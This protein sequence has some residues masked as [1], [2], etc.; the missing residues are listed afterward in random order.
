MF[1]IDEKNS[2]LS[3]LKQINFTKKINNYAFG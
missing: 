3:H 1:E 2:V